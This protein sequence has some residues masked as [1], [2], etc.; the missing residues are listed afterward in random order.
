MVRLL[1]VGTMLFSDVNNAKLGYLWDTLD[2][3][4]TLVDGQFLGD[5]NLKLYQLKKGLRLLSIWVPLVY[6]VMCHYP[7]TWRLQVGFL[8]DTIHCCGTMADGRFLWRHGL[9]L[10]IYISLA[11]WILLRT[12]WYPWWLMVVSLEAIILIYIT[13]NMN[14]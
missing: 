3:F 11:I 5:H 8:W 9:N 7:L 12:L 6:A 10:Y 1:Y 4:G 2:H 13:C 14:A